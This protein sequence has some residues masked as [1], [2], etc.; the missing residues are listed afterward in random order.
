MTKFRGRVEVWTE[1]PGEWVR[2]RVL[3]TRERDGVIEYFV[4]LS[5]MAMSTSDPTAWFASE[6][7]RTA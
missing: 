5:G 1:P 7:L 2:G 6:K 3:D 4:Q